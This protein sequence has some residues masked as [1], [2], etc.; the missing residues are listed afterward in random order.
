MDFSP[1]GSELLYYVQAPGDDS[2]THGFLA[3]ASV[4]GGEVRRLTPDGVD[5]PCCAF[6]SPDGKQI[7]FTELDGR[8]LLIDPES[9]EITEVLVPDG[10]WARN[11]NWSPDGSQIMF[12]LD[13]NPNPQNPAPNEI[14]VINVDGTG[15]TPVV[16]TPDHKEAIFWVPTVPSASN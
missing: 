11:A 14:Y 5:V 2:N 8:L 7:V 3:L 16:V 15:L 4:D 1:D 13:T 10:T 12:T 6:W 9:A